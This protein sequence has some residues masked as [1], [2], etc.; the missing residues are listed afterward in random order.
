MPASQ[1]PS[2]PPEITALLNRLRGRIRN[3]VLIEG[4]ALVLVLA[5]TIFWGSFLFDWA[6]FQLVK[7]EPPRWLRA[8][9]LVAA[10]AGLAAT[11]V[12]LILFRY[13]R[14]FR[15]RSLALVLEKRFPQLDDRLVTAVEASEKWDATASP[16]SAAMLTHTMRDAARAVEQL[17][18][19]D[20]FNQRPLRRAVITAVVLLVSMLGLFVVD[21][22]AMDRWA[23]GY[24]GLHDLYWNRETELVL[25]AVATPGDRVRSFQEGKLKHA[26]GTDLVLQ[27]VVPEG[28][29]VPDRVR[30]DYRLAG[31]RGDGRAYLTQVGDQ[32]FQQALPGLLDSAQIW[33]TG[34]DYTTAVPYVVEVVDPPSLDRVDLA[35]RYPEYTGLNSSAEPSSRTAVAV[36]GAQISLPV[37]TDFILTGVANKPLQQV[38][39]DGEAGGRRFEITLIAPQSGNS[40]RELLDPL[41]EIVLKAEDGQREFRGRFSAEETGA[42]FSPDGLTWK[43]PFLLSLKANEQLLEQVSAAD[44]TASPVKLPLALPPDSFLRISLHDRDDIST[45]EPIRLTIN[46]IP[47][48]PPVVEA[49]LRGIGSSIT[50]MARIPVAGLVSDDYGLQSTQFEFTLDDE[51]EWKPR[52]LSS[53]P[54]PGIREF[55]LSRSEAEPYAR[56]DV[57]PLDLQVK[58]RVTLTIAARDG[59]T[60]NGPHETRSQKF[61]FTIV[62]PEELQSLLYGK[63]LNLRRR[64]EQILSEAKD[65]Q[66][67]L[68]LNRGRVDELQELRQSA[69]P[70]A[71]KITSLDQSLIGCAERCLHGMRKNAAEMEGVH[72]AFSDIRE[73]MINN[74][75]DTPELMN[76]IEAKI[77]APLAAINRTDFPAIDSALGL[78]RLANE[79][80]SNPV[81]AI[82][83]SVAEVGT[84]IQHMEQILQDMRKLESSREIMEALKEIIG[85][86]SEE[87]ERTKQLRKEAALKALQ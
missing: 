45:T 78:F 18:L 66:K 9:V 72:A 35:C 26:R 37:E 80:G 14:S 64:F 71:A 40:E 70:D 4:L 57:L 50:R 62:P 47:D 65:A 27:V 85:G 28:R 33:L 22:S 68:I 7:L 83:D 63:E 75:I 48:L 15:A 1:R 12:A 54:A 21:S 56:F 73:E 60:I 76:R 43:V 61:V 39:I 10:I 2:L 53:P 51:T 5:G 59:D 49:N 32:P 30:L 17:N 20:V 19:T 8:S 34:G 23:R 55:T 46:G 24:L 6:W 69:A 84:L 44:E 11:G 77:V 31:G 74:A 16:L 87:H 58:Q 82:D 38:R 25:Q 52:P 81:S 13:A 42:T 29:K 36:E 41:A 79:K 86:L 67:D 3:Y